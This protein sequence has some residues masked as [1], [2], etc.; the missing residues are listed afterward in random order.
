MVKL[1]VLGSGSR[2]NAF[3]IS[4]ADGAIIIDVGFSRK[5]TRCRMEQLHLHPERL[6]AALLTHEHDDHS[7]GCR[8]FCDELGIPLCTAP[9]TANYLRRKGKLPERVIEFEPGGMFSIGGFEIFPFAVQHDAVNPV[10]FIIRYG[11]CRIGVATDLG[12]VNALALRY[13]ADCD[14]LILESN[15]DE[16]MLRNSDRQLYLKRRILGRNGHLDNRAA[17]AALDQLLTHRTRLLLLAHLSGE[18]NSPELVERLF[19]DRLREM[20]RSDLEFG[21]IRQDVP[22]GVYELGSDGGVERSCAC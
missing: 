7:K 15:Y 20:G 13:L 2:G 3:V 5:E 11:E 10:G 19:S 22:L 14:A 18:C 16:Q 4:S 8:V 12:N 17:L 21:I 1:G 6:D 9:E